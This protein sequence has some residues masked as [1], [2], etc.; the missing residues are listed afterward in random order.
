MILPLQ[1]NITVP[2]IQYLFALLWLLLPT[3]LTAQQHIE[4]YAREWQQV[5]S[6][7]RHGFPESAAKQA[8]V[9]YH[10][11][12]QNGQKTTVMKAQLYLLGAQFERSE[13][14]FFEA[15]Q[16]ADS[17][18]ASAAFPENALW[19]SITATYYWTY[20][21][22]NRW[23]ILDRSRLADHVPVTDFAYWD[24]SRFYARIQELFLSSLSEKEQLQKISLSHYT[25]I[26]SKGK[27]SATL[28]PTLLDLLAFRALDFFENDEKDL[29]KPAFAFTLE[30][31][32]AFAPADQ[33]I[34]YPFTTK[35]TTSL[36]WQALQLY[37][38]L[39]RLHQNDSQ[40]DAFIDADLH[41]LA[42]AWQHS[43]HPEKTDL[44]LKALESLEKAHAGNPL[45]ALAAVRAIAIKIQHHTPQPYP[46]RPANNTTISDKKPDY[47]ALQQKLEAVI[48][49]YPKS[50]GGVQASVM[51]RQILQKELSLHVEEV[52][53]PEK[54]A[55]ILVRYKNIPRIWVQLIPWPGNQSHTEPNT[56]ELKRL[57]AGARHPVTTA[58][59][60]PGTQDLDHHSTEIPIQGLTQGQYIVAVSATEDFS[61]TDNILCTAYFQVSSLSLIT[62][63]NQSGYVLHR[64]TGH[65][66]PGATVNLYQT[67]YNSSSRRQE[68]KLAE[69]LTSDK[70]GTFQYHKKDTYWYPTIRIHT[71]QDSLIVN[72]RF[73]GET[74][75]QNNNTTRTFF[76]TD[77]ALYRPGQTIFYKGIIVRQ[78][79]DGRENTVLTNEKTEAVFYDVNGQE[80]ARQQHHTNEYG[81][82]SGS[83]TAPED[84]LTGNMRIANTTGSVFFGVEAYKRP[85][86]YAAFDTIKA[87]WTLHDSIRIQ[88]NATAYAGNSIDRASVRYRVIR[89]TRFPYYWY[90]YCFGFPRAEEM[91]IT[92][93][94]TTTDT[95]G[96]FTITFQALPDPSVP[97]ASMPVF[98]YNLIADITDINGET[99]STQT[100]VQAGY[101]SLLLT[102]EAPQKTRPEALSAIQIHTRNLNHHFLPA[103][104]TVTISRLKTPNRV[105]RSR[106]WEM[107]DQFVLDSLTF[108]K[109]FPDDAYKNEDDPMTWP[110]AQELFR[111]EITT[112]E[113]GAVD[114]PAHIWKENGWYLLTATTK[115]KN[116]KALTEQKR[117]Q[118]WGNSRSTDA[119]Q[120][121]SVMAE[122][123]TAQPGDVVRL[124]ISSSFTDLYMLQDTRYM[125]HSNKI[126][127]RQYKTLPA[128]QT[129]QIQEHDRGGMA[130]SFITVK[131]NRV[132]EER[133][134]IEVP[135][136]NKQLTL[137]LETHRD[138]LQP[139]E[140]E[141]WTIVI[142]GTQQ[143]ALAAEMAATLYD[144][145]LDAIRPHAW[146][147]HNLF[148]HLINPYAWQK[149][150]GFGQRHSRQLQYFQQPEAAPSYQKTYPSLL[151][152]GNRQQHSPYYQKMQTR[153]MAGRSDA[154]GIS[155]LASGNPMTEGE[156]NMAAAPVEEAKQ[157]RHTEPPQQPAAMR[158]NLRETAFFYPQLHTNAEG[159]IH[160]TFT[161]PEALTTWKLLTFAHTP[162]MQYGHMEGSVKTRKD[163]MVV[164]NLPR[165]LRQ[166]DQIT[167]SA[168]IS[169]ISDQ[170]LNG[171]T[172]LELMNALTGQPVMLPF[173][174]QEDK[175]A[176]SIAPGQSAVTDWHIQVPESM[177]YPVT[178][179]IRATAGNF[180]DGEEHTLPVV[181]N[182][183]L[184][185]ETMPIWING[186]GTRQFNLDKLLHADSSATLSQHAV[187]VD[188][189]S[190]PSW[191]AV[192][193][194]PYLLEYPYECAEQ[195]F[196]R[197]YAN[198]LAQ[199]ITKQVPGIKKMYERWKAE[200]A[201]SS[202][203]SPLEKN[204]TLKTTL[205]Q[206]TPWVIDA[207]RES[208]QKKR[209]ALLFDEDMLA[210]G[211]SRALDKLKQMQLPDGGFGWFRGMS[212]DRYITQYIL[213][214]AGKLLQGSIIDKTSAIH[215]VTNQAL[216]FAD[217]KLKEHYDRMLLLKSGKEHIGAAE[218]Q[219]LYARSFYSETVPASIQPAYVHYQKLATAKWHIFNPYLKGMIALALYRSGD[220]QTP[221]LI[222]QSLRET[223]IR[224]EETGMYW[225][226]ASGYHWQEAAI[227]S[228]SL[229][230][231]CFLEITGDN[232]TVDELKRWLIRHK[233]TNN[234]KTTRAT[235]DACHALLLTGSDWLR[236]SPEVTLQLG[237]TMIHS[238]AMPLEAGSGYF[239]TTIPGNRVQ[240]DMGN[241]TLTVSSPV[242]KA[243]NSPSWGAVYWQYFE[244]M[245]KIKT[246]PGT[247][248]V[249]KE[250]Y[251][252]QH[253]D[254]GSELLAVTQQGKQVIPLQ[255]GDRV[256]TRITLTVD[257]D[258]E[259]IHLKDMRGAC[260]EPV[261]AISGYRWQEGAGYYESIGDMGTDFFFDRLPKG[262]YVFEYPV[263]VSQEGQ[264]SNGISTVQC[265]YAPEFSGHSEGISI[266]TK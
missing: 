214:G 139:G 122:Q 57:I 266:T 217:R 73:T 187:T 138:H 60:L 229:L 207:Q 153:T 127:A 24:V 64:E 30:A 211:Q 233:Q 25:P 203:V 168:K 195:V 125:D 226:Q 141:T 102:I 37:R 199:H 58:F 75:H 150:A 224:N 264:F 97:P 259:Y 246:D 212:S 34:Q 20:Y 152:F 4:P 262:T 22:Q 247:F 85:R 154:D 159:H 47:P 112:T 6:L 191:Y 220:K 48:S 172:I 12:L 72:G 178:I 225:M 167:L 84:V 9:L 181:T 15:I 96:N 18:A 213:A 169:N 171:T 216:D 161:M 61:A 210:E 117:I 68:L 180:T 11:A 80:I 49:R 140:Q 39:L 164:P 87:G 265:M 179:R 70:N 135:W 17:M 103:T 170:A 21:Q 253:S 230:I 110:A 157:E 46:R 201:F 118:V 190:N 162:D 254:R 206:A 109:Q 114:I 93:G 160:L 218:I 227:E 245:D 174:V 202:F 131:N 209:I 142:K 248:R 156:Q 147:I 186:T 77:R 120:T 41:R 155:T 106:L 236:S 94:T 235:A 78:Q 99:Q 134:F 129:Q 165:F 108:K 130:F 86:F 74:R 123:A 228:Q 107:P 92:N 128:L 249:S 33:F 100:T 28:R 144:A 221:A 81:S 2:L 215:P 104:T 255:T 19:K 238:N 14:A 258:M 136:N 198:T 44:Y 234:W 193:S 124:H 194:L 55:R 50:E 88:G 7:L 43:V 35:D 237:D 119:T 182:R 40:Q 91:E 101:T 66:V 185:T 82:F 95:D 200:S 113:T 177:Y 16:Q 158:K 105:L 45:S 148:P 163:L 38:Q 176:F 208:E 59:D 132:Y 62:G 111:K 42:F 188:Y 232:D 54:P 192:Q 69:A 137:A 8:T 184:V 183:M 146:T 242:G 166:G 252:E 126:Q 222:I 121:L 71:A 10:K 53:L 1:K 231:S 76:F 67:T 256:K 36:Q 51:L 251:V 63:S 89:K 29:T 173:R 98:S 31:A 56:D 133:C 3:S 241:I 243:Q 149:D 32:A 197:Y 116:G 151:L 52:I 90:A 250:L 205:L 83:F 196:N 143:E 263:F 261:Q 115:D 260:F 27:N 5:D 65:P 219:Y 79:Q 13:T 244:N 26:L 145:S 189:A 23:K 257:R 175:K 240:P 239:K 223:A 204:E